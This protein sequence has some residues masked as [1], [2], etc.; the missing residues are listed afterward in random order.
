[1]KEEEEEVRVVI[2]NREIEKEVVK[3]EVDIIT[4]RSTKEPVL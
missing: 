3:K 2:T 1:M 4:S